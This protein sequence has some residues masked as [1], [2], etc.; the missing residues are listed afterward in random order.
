MG[1][2]NSNNI[3]SHRRSSGDHSTDAGNN[4]SNSNNSTEMTTT[5]THNNNNNNSNSNSNNDATLKSEKP[6]FSPLEIEDST[7][8]S[9]IDVDVDVDVDV[10]DDGE[11]INPLV[12]DATS[13]TTCTNTSN[14]DHDHHGA[15][16]PGSASTPQVII[17]IIISFVGAGL[18]GVPNAFS[19]SGWLLGSITLLTVSALNVYG[20]LCLPQVQRVLQKQYPNEIIQSYG[21]LGRICLGTKGEKLIFICLGI[22]QAGFATAYLIFISANLNSIYN[23]SRFIVCILCVPGLIGLVQFRDLKSLSPFSMLANGANFCALS[24][25]LFQ[26]YEHYTPHNDTIQKWNSN[27]L[28]YVIAITI[29]SMEGVGLILSLK[30]SCKQPKDFSFLLISTLTAISLFMVIFGSAGYWAFGDSTMAPITLNMASHWSATFVKC[31]L[32]L[33]L[34][35]TYPIMMFP[36]WTIIETPALSNQKRFLIRSTIV[37]LSAIIAYAVPNFGQ[38]L[39]LVGSSICTLLGFVFPSYFHLYVVGKDLPLYQ[40]IIDSFL[41]VGGL[42]FGCLGTYQSLVAMMNGELEAE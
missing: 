3:I 34:Y 11:L 23:W 2:D 35:L 18:L 5:S 28:L 29:Y 17:N 39:S 33:G 41:L 24:A 19:K 4:N 36:I 14:N 16:P 20:M 26:D 38:F 10:D 22:S 15:G 12:A 8:T 31:A 30:S 27:G 42:S 25:V 7:T 21:D 40:K 37:C 6:T 13:T 9:A 1:E 32:C